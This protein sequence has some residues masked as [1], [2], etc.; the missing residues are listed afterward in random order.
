MGEFLHRSRQS[1]DKNQNLHQSNNIQSKG[2]AQKHK[3]QE[4]Q[5]DENISTE[6]TTTE[7]LQR[8]WDSAESGGDERN[9]R[10]GPVLPIEE[11]EE[12]PVQRK[13]PEP[14][15][16]FEA[17]TEEEPVQRM[18]PVPIQFHASEEEEP[19]QRLGPVP[20]MVAEDHE[21]EPIQR[22]SPIP[23]QFY[24]TETEEEPVQRKGPVPPMSEEFE[25]SN[26]QSHEIASD[27]LPPT[28]QA[29]MENS[30]G[31]DFSDISIHKDSSQ[32]KDLNAYAYTQG[33]NIHFA[34]GQY[35]PESQKGQELI[36]HELT[37]VVQQK[38]G[39][40]QPTV[41]KKGVGINDDEALEKEADEMGAK[42]AKGH[43]VATSGN[44]LGG[45]S[46]PGTIQ[47]SEDDDLINEKIKIYN[48]QITEASLLYGI[49]E[50]QIRLL[51]AQCSKGEKDF[52]DGQSFG[53]LGL[54]E[55]LWS[56]T[57]V[58]F[59]ELANYEFG[60][61]WNDARANILL[62]VAAYKLQL[63]NTPSAE[64]PVAEKQTSDT[65]TS[66][67]ANPT[68]SQNDSTSASDSSPAQ[69]NLNEQGLNSGQP[70]AASG[71]PTKIIVGVIDDLPIGSKEEIIKIQSA[72]KA[73]GYYSGNADGMIT[74]KDKT[75]SGTVKAI[76]DYQKDNH[77]PQT[78]NVD[79]STNELLI[80]AVSVLPAPP[81]ESPVV[82]KPKAPTK[83][84]KVDAEKIPQSP[85][86]AVKAVSA[87]TL[88]SEQIYAKHRGEMLAIGRELLPYAKSHPDAIIKMLDYLTWSGDNLAYN[89]SSHLSEADLP[90]LSKDLIQR[91]YDELDSGYTSD[92]EQ[93]QMQKLNK[94]LSVNIETL[95]ESKLPTN[96]KD[97]EEYFVQYEKL[98]K[99]ELDYWYSS[100]NKGVPES[101][102]V[103]PDLFVKEARRI[104]AEKHD[105]K[106]IVPVQFALAQLKIEGGLVGGQRT[107]GN[108]FN[109]G[110]KDSG[111]TNY[112]KSIT[113]M[114]KGFKAYYS[115]MAD[116]YLS[117]KGANEL[118]NKDS[119]RHDTGVYATNPYYEMEI[120]S[121]IGLMYY[122]TSQYALSGTVGNKGNNNA[123][124]IAIVGSLLNKVGYLKKE[125]I[126]D[127]NKVTEGIRKFQQI[128]M[129]PKDEKWFKERLS[130][131]E[132]ADD[133]KS[134]TSKSEKF[135]DGNVL[136]NGQTIGLL[137]YMAVLNGKIPNGGVIV[138]NKGESA[139]NSKSESN[140]NNHK[141]NGDLISI[142]DEIFR[143]I[144]GF[145]TDE[146][147]IF[148][149]LAKLNH[150]QGMIDELKKSYSS[151]YKVSLIED[152]KGDL[153]GSDL[154]KAM[155]Y[156]NIMDKD[157]KEGEFE[158]KS[159][160]ASYYISKV[161]F[162]GNADPSIVK[163]DIRYILGCLADAAG[164]SNVVV[165]GTARTALKQAQVMY[166]YLSIGD[167]MGY[168]APGERVQQVYYKMKKEGKKE[169]EIINSMYQKILEEGPENVSAHCAD[170]SKK[171]TVDLGYGSNEMTADQEKKFI[172][173]V[174]ELMKK[175]IILDIQ[176]K[177][178]NKK[179]QAYHLVI[180]V[181]KSK[182]D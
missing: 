151:K 136:S 181:A 71:D 113:T 22:R 147:A 72:L 17:E 107:G 168:K 169:E 58:K 40:V 37:H 76:E 133:K 12:E 19:I 51:I 46:F 92:L 166:Y 182:R 73:L 119:F 83:P 38:A 91:L 20:S 31:E 53:L 157:A 167:D 16:L 49:S 118:L 110:A 69:D 175:G 60:S 125:D 102:R 127:L 62:G 44:T 77:L 13:G 94:F 126:S 1:S 26:E 134:I 10:S 2:V 96:P 48:E 59:P 138:D 149:A 178:N 145:G 108:V 131:V 146:E 85:K 114:E 21:E 144:D 63:A 47:Q 116:K 141:G 78:G 137:Y 177:A 158:D 150:N 32:S 153:S 6:S 179:E 143:A 117:G 89:I 56:E 52:T 24:A 50:D 5:T 75:E 98:A 174:G 64:A 135:V 97:I 74:R 124:D 43:I 27:K 105:L 162:S 139:S 112:E 161:K 65:S 68:D 9:K 42:A 173:K 39:R 29:K 87:P 142:G 82:H 79:V 57:K 34:P 33:T 164:L 128:E 41:Q 86:A 104:Y 106:Y 15:Q 93:L 111:V 130:H 61:S 152:L 90:G 109:V 18:G 165:T 155:Q 81:A 66:I 11:E 103:K 23:L 4:A 100:S 45:N 99:R 159:K 35:N 176:W 80:T 129:S 88:T 28:V 121:E 120:K 101:D 25:I 115:I 55:P 172:A 132:R 14:L 156:L 67:L 3:T 95:S 140:M 160:N 7:V 122:R 163:D 148:V 123:K 171:V 36:G 84:K 8:K 154:K 30:F 180:D 70:I 54:T 170:Y